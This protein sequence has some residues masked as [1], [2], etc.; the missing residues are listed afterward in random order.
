ML[1]FASATI[2]IL[3]QNNINFNMIAIAFTLNL[4]YAVLYI[5]ALDIYIYTQYCSTQGLIDF[6]TWLNI[7]I[8]IP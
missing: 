1:G 6:R 3:F 7:I 4:I 8:I 5:R 2:I